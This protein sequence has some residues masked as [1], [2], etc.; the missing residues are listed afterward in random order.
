MEPGY[1]DREHGCLNQCLNGW[2]NHLLRVVSLIALFLAATLDASGFL[3]VEE[4]T[5]RSMFHQTATHT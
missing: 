2:P 4:G 1:P 5:K 3:S